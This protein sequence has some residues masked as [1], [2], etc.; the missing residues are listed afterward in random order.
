MKSRNFKFRLKGSYINFRTK[1]M[2]IQTFAWD[3]KQYGQPTLENL[4][5]F[6][7]LFNASITSKDGA[8]THLAEI[9]SGLSKVWI[10][11]NVP[12]HVKPQVKVEY[13]PP[14]FEEI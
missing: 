11:T 13:N 6:R 8:N 10:E 2:D 4:K 5:K 7:K 12:Y 14:A 1:K 3:S 9:Q